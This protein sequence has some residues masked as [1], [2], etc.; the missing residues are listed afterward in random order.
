MLKIVFVLIIVALVVYI[1]YE[2]YHLKRDYLKKQNHICAIFVE[3][4]FSR[5]EE[6]S[7]TKSALTRFRKYRE[8]HAS[9]ESI[10]AIVGGH[11]KLGK[12]VDSDVTEFDG[13]LHKQE[14]YAL[15]LL[16]QQLHETV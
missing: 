15:T 12:L 5:A 16:K 6:A 8:A 7:D 1:V 9:L 14:N 4:V 10:A 2:N 3:D 11:E 13:K